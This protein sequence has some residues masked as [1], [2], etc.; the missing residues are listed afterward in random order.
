MKK[1]E[2]LRKKYK[3]FIYEKY[4]IEEDDFKIK[5]TYYFEIPSLTVFTPVIK[6]NKKDIKK[7][8]DMSNYLIFLVGMIELI[9]Y[10]K[11]VCPE[12]IIV[13]AGTLNDDEVKF[14]K[15]LY[16]NGL[17]ELLYLNNIN[18]SEEDFVSIECEKKGNIPSVN[19]RG[20]GNLIPVGGG[21][22]S[23]V[24]LELLSGKHNIN[25]PFTI[26][27]KKP[28]EECILKANKDYDILNVE[29]I[30]D[31]KIIELNNLGFINGH[32][33]F[34]SLIAF[35]S[36]LLAYENNKEYIVLS[37]ENS[38][39]ESTVKNTKINHQY[40]K[41]L[42]FENDFNSLVKD[43]LKLDITYFSILRPLNE[44]T[45][46]LLFSKYKKYHSVF[47]SCNKGSK[48]EEWV[49]CSNCPKCLFTYIILSPFLKK[50]EL[51]NIFKEDLFNKESLL[52]TF[53]S[54][55]GSSNVKP[56]ECVGTVR[57]VRTALCMVV[58]NYKEKLPIL[59]EYY[60]DNY[61]LEID[62]NILKEYHE[63]NLNL[64]FEKILKSE[65][66]KC[67]KNL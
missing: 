56:F 18:I 25:T 8:D 17:S 31:K 59:L 52:D 37:C 41:T 33:P 4:D 32:T 3:T 1:F 50:E 11:A 63:N 54:L 57:E 15:K 38:A 48:G 35:L 30:L 62:K 20:I 58:D 26:N 64:E 44:I 16:Y 21:K 51:L 23:C 24:T 13:R 2:D 34:S 46:A 6:I 55:I 7:L 19:Y 49:F 66:L 43:I 40:S 5:I 65:V 9:S 42:E 29:R 27:C 10:Y 36:L 14:F 53:K 60:K 47:R 61:D 45:I 39:N 28:M 67:L 12:K 22:D